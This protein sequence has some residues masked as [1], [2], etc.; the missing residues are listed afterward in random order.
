MI[1][2]TVY[3][4]TNMHSTINTFK[5]MN[6]MGWQ[7]YGPKMN[8]SLSYPKPVVSGQEWCGRLLKMTSPV[9]VATGVVTN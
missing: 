7:P 4:Q 1:N 2:T 3:L 6:S 5:A 9:I 8:K